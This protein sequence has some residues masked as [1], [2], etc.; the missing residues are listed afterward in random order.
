MKLKNNHILDQI[1]QVISLDLMLEEDIHTIH[2]ISENDIQSINKSVHKLRK[3]LK[4]ISA[5]LFLYE[6]QI[7]QSQYLNWKS[8]IK[9]LSKQFSE[10]REYF[11]HLQT[12]KKV[13]DKLKDIDKSDLFEIR[14]QFESE[15]DQIVQRVTVREKTILKGK[16]AILKMCQEIQNRHIHSELKLLERR[17]LKSNQKAQKQFKKLSLNSSHN[18]FHEFRKSCKRFYLQHIVYNRLGFEKTSKQNKKLYQL[19]EYLGKEHDLNL[20]YEFLSIH[21]HELPPLSQSFFM[22]KIRK[23]RKNVFMLYPEVNY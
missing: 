4:S 23:L 8:E 2:S 15:Y 13:E 19:T 1:G 14:T 6:F 12:F 9:S 18:E 5:I 3:S 16:E 17:L 22:H 7:D 11:I 20:L 10:V 21:F